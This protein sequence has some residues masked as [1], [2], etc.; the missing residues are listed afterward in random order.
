MTWKKYGLNAATLQVRKYGCG[1]WRLRVLNTT[2]FG[3]ASINLLR[4]TALVVE[5]QIKQGQFLFLLLFVL[6]ILVVVLHRYERVFAL[7]RYF[8]WPLG[9]V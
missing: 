3:G 1:A 7:S 9:S 2:S 6:L 8:R 4:E 5:I